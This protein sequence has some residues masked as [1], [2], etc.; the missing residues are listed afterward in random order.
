MVNRVHI[1]FSTGLL[2]LLWSAA[3]VARL[4]AQ[5][6]DSV[7]SIRRVVQRIDRKAT[8]RFAARGQRRPVTGSITRLTADSVYVQGF[9]WP[10]GMPLAGVDTVWEHAGRRD[11]DVHRGFL[12]GAIAGAVLGG[13]LASEL[14]SLSDSVNACSAPAVLG[15]AVVGSLFFGVMGGVIMGISSPAPHWEQRWP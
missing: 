5:N 3:P 15:G 1:R 2:L 14:C 13:W 4:A 7:T 8:V 6:P 10:V 9:D 11:P 12:V